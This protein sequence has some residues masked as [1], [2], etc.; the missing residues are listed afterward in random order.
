MVG[1]C[2]ITAFDVGKMFGKLAPRLFDERSAVGEKQYVFTH[3][4]RISSST[5]EMAVQVLPVPV[6][7][8]N[9]P[10]SDACG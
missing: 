5:S 2:Q 9:S 3:P 6:A 4:E 8:T 10:P 1:D 7:I